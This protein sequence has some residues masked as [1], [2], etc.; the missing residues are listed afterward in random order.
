M[1]QIEGAAGWVKTHVPSGIGRLGMIADEAGARS[2]ITSCGNGDGGNGDGM[3]VAVI[4]GSLKW[5]SKSLC[6]NQFDNE[7][8][9]A[10]YFLTT[11]LFNFV[12][13]NNCI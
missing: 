12:N 1:Q 9:I 7:L 8:N 11:N 2:L 5:L 13:L 4:V 10:L 6:Y 3:R